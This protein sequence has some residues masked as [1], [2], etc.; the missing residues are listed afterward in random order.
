MGIAI[1]CDVD[2]ALP[3]TMI[4]P[5]GKKDLPPLH[6]FIVKLM[7]TDVDLQEFL[8]KQKHE[9]LFS[10]QEAG[11]TVNQIALFHHEVLYKILLVS[12]ARI[13]FHDTQQIPLLYDITFFADASP[14]VSVYQQDKDSSQ[15]RILN[16]SRM[17]LLE[18]KDQNYFYTAFEDTVL[19]ILLNMFIFNSQTAVQILDHKNQNLIEMTSAEV[20][21]DPIL[22]WRAFLEFLQCDYKFPHLK[23]FIEQQ[24]QSLVEEIVQNQELR[25]SSIQLLGSDPLAL[26]SIVNYRLSLLEKMNI[27]EIKSFI[28]EIILNKQAM[29]LPGYIKVLKCDTPDPVTTIF[30]LHEK[31]IAKQE[32]YS[33]SIVKVISSLSEILEEAKSAFL[34][35]EVLQKEVP[36]AQNN[37]IEFVLHKS[38]ASKNRT[39]Q[40]KQLREIL[41]NAFEQPDALNV[42]EVCFQVLN[43]AQNET[44]IFHPQP[45]GGFTEDVYL[46]HIPL[47]YVPFLELQRWTHFELLPDADHSDRYSY[48]FYAHPILKGKKDY[49]LMGISLVLCTE[50]HS[51]ALGCQLQEIN[52]KESMFSLINALQAS[53]QSHSSEK[54]PVCNRLFFQILPILNTT[55]TEITE[56]VRTLIEFFEGQCV[57]LNLEKIIFK[58]R[59]I[60]P[61]VER[62]HDTVLIEYKYVGTRPKIDVKNLN[63]ET[64]SSLISPA[65][66]DESRE[67]EIKSK[68]GIY[69]SRI[70]EY[71]GYIVDKFKKTELGINFPSTDIRESFVELDLD[72]YTLAND[73]KTGTLDFNKGKLV[74]VSRPIGYHEAGVLI[75]IMTVDLQIGFPMQSLLLIGD[76]THTKRGAITAH[77]CARINAAIRYAA[78]HELPVDW[79][80]ASHGVEIQRE[81]G[82]E[83]LDA[84]SSTVRE[85]IHYSH[86][87]GVQINLVIHETNIGAQSYWDALA[88]MMYETSGILVMTPRG[89]MA[90]T[91]PSALVS[92]L[93][94]T[95]HSLDL[96]ALAQEYYPQ[97]LQSLSGY[98]LVHGPNSDAMLFAKDLE[99]ACELIIR[100]HYYSYKKQGQAVVSQRPRKADRPYPIS[101]ADLQRELTKF[102][103]GAKPNREAILEALQDPGS[104]Y[105]IRFWRDIKAYRSQASKKGDFPQEPSIIV[106][107]MQIGGFPTMVIFSPRGPLTPVDSDIMARAIFKASGR[108]PVLIIGNLTGFSC[109]PLSMENRQLFT[110][111][112]IAK[113]IV[114]HKGPI[115]IVNLGLLVGGTF[116]VF[117][118]QLNPNLRILAIAGSR[119]QV[120]GGKA[121]AKV[122]F[123]S[124]IC[125]QADEDP[126]LKKIA[127]MI[128]KYCGEEPPSQKQVELVKSYQE[129]RREVIAE[130]ENKEGEAFDNIHNVERAF[131]VGSIDEVLPLHNFQQSIIRHLT[132]MVTAYEKEY[133]IA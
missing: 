51:S 56:H 78:Q 83:G 125:K 34:I 67:R 37:R 46:R 108:I 126:R 79:Y 10:M 36:K 28:E 131:R 13:S 38:N 25:E 1:C 103:K 98:E 27:P 111:A 66:H 127:A 72:P 58:A 60:N 65:T 29:D 86:H 70:P 48:L 20:I 16:I 133:R 93:F 92:A 90:L 5:N 85:I 105:P 63:V 99:E 82:V 106:Q 55:K 94:T 124:R 121:A 69:A 95:A 42:K 47:D 109:D 40:S 71:I 101:D 104:P 43:P 129:L 74:K 97:G 30:H 114:D 54:R 12:F 116:V 4:D 112:L 88:S 118:K 110:G 100:H 35:L 130:I 8:A 49:R 128:E 33:F 9:K 76:I 31:D 62:G 107:E 26:H 41:E 45:T 7:S 81:R 73:P 80:A 119:V 75:G 123:H 21:K 132:E 53:L 117:S 102:I 68:G 64:S 115:L 52:I 61:R 120:I 22:R 57:G 11:E 18:K 122:V 14:E 17:K 3:K 19:E 59:L 50:L 96:P 32:R 44:Y 2:E 89:S 77:E 87:K 91:G 84:S 23:Q 113:S 39:K 24:T 15:L 6:P